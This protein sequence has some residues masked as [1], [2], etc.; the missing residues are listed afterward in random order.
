[1]GNINFMIVKYKMHQLFLTAFLRAGAAILVTGYMIS[2]LVS[3]AKLNSYVG[4][5]NTSGVQDHF[6]NVLCTGFSSKPGQ[7]NGLRMRLPIF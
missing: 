1:M 7:I 2:E 3:G 5:P 6:F 4:C